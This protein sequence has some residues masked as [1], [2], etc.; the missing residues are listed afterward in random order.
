MWDNDGDFMSL[1]IFSKPENVYQ[2][3]TQMETI[4]FGWSWSVEVGSSVVTNVP[5]GQ[6]MMIV[7]GAMH[8]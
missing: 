1:Y 5:L 6:G 7:R 3:W 8:L 4:N 2:E